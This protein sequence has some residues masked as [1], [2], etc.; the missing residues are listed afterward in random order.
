MS[1]ITFSN[2]FK[3]K[4][5]RVGKSGILQLNALHFVE[6]SELPSRKIHQPLRVFP[7][8]S[9][10][11][12]SKKLGKEDWHEKSQSP[13]RFRSCTPNKYLKIK[14]SPSYVSESFMRSKYTLGV[15]ESYVYTEQDSTSDINNCPKL[16]KIKS[17][18]YDLRENFSK[19]RSKTR[20]SKYY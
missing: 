5:E 18:S 6:K 8:N 20:V 2:R 10:I 13:E 7:T 11:L 3:N 12:I 14:K 15:S 4:I 1:S 9:K 17:V 16:P 19:H